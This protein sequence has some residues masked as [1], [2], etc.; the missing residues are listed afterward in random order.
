MYESQWKRIR[1]TNEKTFVTFS[2]TFGNNVDL[3]T[4]IFFFKH[5]F[6]I[7]QFSLNF[8]TL[9]LN[10]GSVGNFSHFFF[11]ILWEKLSKHSL[12]SQF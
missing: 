9:I 5:L 8:L 10:F 6:E 7:L 12:I 11:I 2:L 3:R 1:A 4:E